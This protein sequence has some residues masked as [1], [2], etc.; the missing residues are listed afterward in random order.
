M[1]QERQR[2]PN[3]RQV[4][5]AIASGWSDWRAK[6]RHEVDKFAQ[7]WLPPSKVL[8][9]GCGNGRNLA[10]FSARGFDCYGVDFSG[11]M[12]AVA[13]KSFAKGKLRAKFKVADARKLPYRSN[14]FEHCLFVAILHHLKVDKDR[15][16]A[17]QE[18]H[19][20]LRPGGTA[21]VSVWNK[22]SFGHPHLTLKPK[23]TYVAWNR[24]GKRHMRYYYLFSKWELKRLI[25]RSG[26]KILKSGGLLD[27]NIVF[28]VGKPRILRS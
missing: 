26:L 11:K 13:E 24:K 6:P 19:R 25:E 9:I 5:D 8:D 27:D 18:M 7:D 1:K 2:R 12:I 28:L 17:L 3:Q 20:V 15:M 23:E 4:W 14:S 21:I 10:Q 22:Y 16:A